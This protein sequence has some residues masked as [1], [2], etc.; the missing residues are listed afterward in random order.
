[1]RAMNGSQPI[2]L[3]GTRGQLIRTLFRQLLTLRKMQDTASYG[4]GSS[5]TM[6]AS[7]KEETVVHVPLLASDYYDEPP[8]NLPWRLLHA[9]FFLLG[10]TTFIAGIVAL[11]Y[12][13]NDSLSAGLYTLGSSTVVLFYPGN[14]SLSAG[15]YTLGSIGFFSVDAQGFFPQ[16]AMPA[17]GVWGFILGSFVIGC[18]QFWKTYRIASV[19]TGYFSLKTLW[20]DVESFTAAGVELSA[21]LGAWCFFFGTFLYWLGPLE[22]PESV[23]H[24]VLQ[25]WVMGSAWF[26]LGGCFLAHRH[27]VMVLV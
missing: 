22:G 20:D 18:S 5:T 15:L 14:D 7:T 8:P 9:F 21:G 10:G 26:T 12:P 3:A 1:M 2:W 13:G 24:E 11:F 19:E 17:I 27:F 6:T 16:L 23:V 4:A 25:I